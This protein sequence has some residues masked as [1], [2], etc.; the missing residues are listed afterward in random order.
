M[1]PVGAEVHYSVWDSKEATIEVK[2]TET[3]SQ[4]STSIPRSATMIERGR[5]LDWFHDPTNDLHF[6]RPSK[7]Y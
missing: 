4:Y 6:L 5:G 2:E 3:L 7:G 1:E